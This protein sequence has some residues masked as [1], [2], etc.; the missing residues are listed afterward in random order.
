MLV[1]AIDSKSSAA[2]AV[3]LAVG[4]NPNRAIETDDWL[5]TQN[6]SVAAPARKHHIL[7]YAIYH[8]APV[9]IIQE[10]IKAKAKVYDKFYGWSPLMVIGYHNKVH[11][12]RMLLGL[13]PFTREQVEKYELDERIHFTYKEIFS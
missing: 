3:A 13:L 6:S 8:D 5:G 9:A 10:L 2:V 4:A 1:H 11:Y 7:S 12:G